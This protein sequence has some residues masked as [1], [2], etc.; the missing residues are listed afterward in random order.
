MN[1]P[2]HILIVEDD[3][4]LSGML[5][6]LL[7]AEHFRVTVAEDGEIGM[8]LAAELRPDFL[9]VDID[10]PKINGIIMLKALRGQGVTSPA[11]MLTNL[12]RPDYI[13]EAAELGIREYLIKA[14]WEIDKIVAKIKG[15][16][17]P[18]S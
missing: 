16:L 15:H 8:K 9:V 6:Q 4:V 7:E 11:I 1:E 12:S 10:M 18:R 17:T 5:G 3:H 13:A 14:D 2:K